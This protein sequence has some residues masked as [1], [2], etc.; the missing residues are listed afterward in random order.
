VTG[1][2]R[3]YDTMKVDVV[4]DRT[5][6]ITEKKNRQTVQPLTKS[7]DLLGRQHGLLGIRIELCH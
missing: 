2:P 6:M 5:V 4:D 3:Y 7:S 1:H